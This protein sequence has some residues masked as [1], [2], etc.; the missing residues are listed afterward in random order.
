M[1]SLVHPKYKTKYRITNW[2]D[3]DKAL[4]RRGDII[5]WIS[6]DAIDTW[7]P[8]CSDK[9]GAPSKYSDLAISTALTLRLVYRIPLQQA[10]G[11]LRS[12][13]RIIGLDLNTPDHTSLSPRSLQ[14]RLALDLSVSSG[15]ID[16]IV[17]QHG[18]LA[19]RTRRVG[20][21]KAR[22]TRKARLQEASH[23]R[24]CSRRDRCTG[25]DRRKCL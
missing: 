17:R 20:S 7:T 13:L 9:R 16:V 15:P 19:R 2:A 23:R 14:F 1:Q 6:Q 22:K 24:H 4:V 21:C 11:F 18:P 12:L 10:E 25:L 5:L 8:E 3:N